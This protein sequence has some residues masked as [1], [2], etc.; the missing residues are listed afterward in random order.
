MFWYGT[1]MN[2]WGAA[3]MGIGMLAFWVLLIGMVLTVL[4]HNRT[5][6]GHTAAPTPDQLLA[7]RFARGDIDRDE[8]VAGQAALRDHAGL[9]Q[10]G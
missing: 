9:T 2:G 3:L 8:Y 7:G 1:G 6:H 4:R 5:D 10:R